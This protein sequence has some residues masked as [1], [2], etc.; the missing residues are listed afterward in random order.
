MVGYGCRAPYGPSEYSDALAEG[1]GELDVPILNC[2]DPAGPRLWP[3]PCARTETAAIELSSKKLR[4]V[5]VV[6]LA[7]L[8]CVTSC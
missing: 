3:L 8:G 1:T 6:I 4:I 7:S 2:V 5:V